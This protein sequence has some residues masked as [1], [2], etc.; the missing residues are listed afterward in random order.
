MT[1]YQNEGAY[2]LG[3]NLIKVWLSLS[4]YLIIKIHLDSKKLAQKKNYLTLSTYT[5]VHSEYFCIS[6][7]DLTPLNN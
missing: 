6:Y 7:H 5:E 3:C 1:N 4:L 2:V